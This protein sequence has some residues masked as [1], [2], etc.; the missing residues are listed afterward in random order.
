MLGS[1][2]RHS[3]VAF[4]RQIA[5]HLRDAV[6]SGQLGPGD[7]IPSERELMEHYGVQRETVRQAIALLRSEGVLVAR[8]GKGVFVR[9]IAPVVRVS[10]S[11]FSRKER[12]GKGLPAFA[13]E[14]ARL[15]R[16]WHQELTEVGR[17]PVPPEAAERLRIEP[18]TEVAVRRRRMYVEGVPLQLADSYVPLQ[19]AEGTAILEENSGPGGIYSRIEEK[20]HRLSHATEELQAR[21]PQP[22]ERSQLALDPGVP[23]V[24]LIRTAFDTDDNPVEVLLSV[25][26]GDKQVF[27]YDVSLD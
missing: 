2:D 12:E 8:H 14:M 7:R 9:E 25:V 16:E 10:S 11:R 4:Y 24:T 20:G 18:G 22:E 1:L 13:A 5:G 3:D 19:I 23:V 17:A 6:T 21:M 15:G 27:V 26:A